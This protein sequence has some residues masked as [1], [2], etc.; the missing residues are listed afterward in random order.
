MRNAGLH[1]LE[2]LLCTAW[3]WDK[4]A[5]FSLR[6]EGLDRSM[7]VFPYRL[8][9]VSTSGSQSVVLRNGMLYTTKHLGSFFVVPLNTWE[10]RYVGQ[11]TPPAVSMSHPRCCINSF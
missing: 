8:R 7:L 6:N 4:L 3:S 1:I 11:L 5:W 9:K 2:F 10:D